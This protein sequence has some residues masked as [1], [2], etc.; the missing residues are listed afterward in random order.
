MSAFST[1]SKVAAGATAF[2]GVYYGFKVGSYIFKENTF[3]SMSNEIY[4]ENLKKILTIIFSASSRTGVTLPDGLWVETIKLAWI[5]SLGDGFA[6]KTNPSVQEQRVIA[7][8]L[9]EEIFEKIIEKIELKSAYE[10][11]S[12]AHKGLSN[13]SCPAPHGWQGFIDEFFTEKGYEIPVNEQ[14]PYWGQLEFIYEI[15]VAATPRSQVVL[16]DGAWEGILGMVLENMTPEDQELHADP[17]SHRLLH[18]AL[19]EH[20]YERLIKNVG[21]NVAYN[22]ICYA[23]KNLNDKSCPAHCGWDKFIETFFE[24]KGLKFESDDDISP[25]SNKGLH[26]TVSR[27]GSSS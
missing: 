2:T 23:H 7:V 4:W 1:M 25:P 14:G 21:L 20:V 18:I 22:R 10:K 11:I 6:P 13:T 19:I 3:R 26:E 8:T 15:L 5:R 9:V 27:G 17:R 12:Y 16:N 24:E